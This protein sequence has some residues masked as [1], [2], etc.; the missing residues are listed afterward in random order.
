MTP[1]SIA[2]PWIQRT[3]RAIV[4][5]TGTSQRRFVRA[6]NVTMA[7]DIGSRT[8]RAAI[9][10]IVRGPSSTDVDA[11][12]TSIQAAQGGKDK[13]REPRRVRR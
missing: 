1:T 11:P 10:V 8:Q 2:A 5:A 12:I 7:A 13:D 3:G 4:Q 9:V 6:A